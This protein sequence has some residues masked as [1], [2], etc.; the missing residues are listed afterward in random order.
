MDLA[1]LCSSTTEYGPGSDPELSVP[2]H[3]T[4]FLPPGGVFRVRTLSTKDI[5]IKI[6]R[7]VVTYDANLGMIMFSET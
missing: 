4:L 3:P 2:S 6:A 7:L 1:C 5:R